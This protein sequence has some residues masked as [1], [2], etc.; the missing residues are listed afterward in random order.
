MGFP[1]PY[2]SFWSPVVSQAAA[3][4]AAAALVVWAFLFGPARDAGRIPRVQLFYARFVN[5]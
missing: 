4:A 1:S 5:V 3:A 2:F